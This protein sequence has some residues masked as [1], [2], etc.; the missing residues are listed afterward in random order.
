MHKKTQY[1]INKIYYSTKIFRE[2][3][4]ETMM[5][6]LLQLKSIKEKQKIF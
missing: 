4:K 2:N 5:E 1:R 6:I 3:L